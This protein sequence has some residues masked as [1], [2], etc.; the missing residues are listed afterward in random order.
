VHCEHGVFISRTCVHC[1]ILLCFKDIFFCF[2][3][4]FNGKYLHD[5]FCRK[6]SCIHFT[7]FF[8]LA[9][10]ELLAKTV[11]KLC[12]GSNFSNMMA[13]AHFIELGSFVMFF[14]LH[15]KLNNFCF[16]LA[17]LVLISSLLSFK[18][19]LLLCNYYF[20]R[21]NV[22]VLYVC[23]GLSCLEFHLCTFLPTAISL[24]VISKRLFASYAMVIT[25][26]S[27]AAEAHLVQFYTIF[28]SNSQI[29]MQS[30][31]II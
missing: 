26:F 19:L 18:N 23:R 8:Y 7:Y 11:C 21:E 6:L 22:R 12:F 27:M 10:C 2:L 20:Y 14:R 15:S 17:K 31:K 9:V 5:M 13:R 1:Q 4:C 25:F 3:D 24:R 30:F 28:R 29:N 16:V